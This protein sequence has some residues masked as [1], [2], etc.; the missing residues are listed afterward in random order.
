ME[1]DTGKKGLGVLDIIR[2]RQSHQKMLLCRLS[3]FIPKVFSPEGFLFFRSVTTN[4]E[5]ATE[6]STGIQNGFD[7]GLGRSQNG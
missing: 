3:Q 5:E 7:T 4:L 1:V 6:I 2:I